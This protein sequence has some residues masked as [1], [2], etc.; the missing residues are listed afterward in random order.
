MPDDP[1]PYC[2]REGDSWWE[3]YRKREQFTLGFYLGMFPFAA[4]IVIRHF[5]WA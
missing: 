4:F 2:P 1:C 3:A 5:G